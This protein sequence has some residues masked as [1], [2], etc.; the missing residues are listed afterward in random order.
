MS[1]RGVSQLFMFVTRQCIDNQYFLFN[2]CLT[3][4]RKQIHVYERKTS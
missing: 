2:F 4:D 3:N 1:L